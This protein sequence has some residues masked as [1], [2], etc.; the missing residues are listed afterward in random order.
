LTDTSWENIRAARMAGLDTYYGS[1]VSERADRALDLVGIGRMLA[2][3]PVAEV[4]ALA[5]LRYRSEFGPEVYLINTKPEKGGS[6][7]HGETSKPLGRQ[8]FG[9]HITFAKLASLISQGAEV[10]STSLTEAFTFADLQKKYPG[11]MIALFA[12]SPRGSLRLFTT[13]QRPNPENGWKVVYLTW[14]PRE[15]G[16]TDKTRR[17][18]PPAPA[19]D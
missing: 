6:R 18:S 4:N 13:Q 17:Q 9:E 3:T 5:V 1:A 19:P 16:P 10:R 14:T 15:N 12:V 2:L 11:R 8:L 7:K